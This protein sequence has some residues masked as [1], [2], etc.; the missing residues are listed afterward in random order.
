MI[1]QKPYQQEMV[2]RARW[3]VTIL[4][5]CFV[6]LI[7][8][9]L[10][11]Q[12]LQHPL[13][14]ERAFQ[15]HW[16]KQEL[17]ARRGEIRDRFGVLLSMSQEGYS[18]YTDPREVKNAA[19]TAQQL[20]PL[21]EMEE[22]KLCERLSHPSR[23]FV[24]LKRLLTPEK[25][26]QVQALKLPG[27]YARP[28]PRRVYPN[29]TLAAHVLGFTNVDHQGLEGVEASFD[30]ELT[31]TDG[32]TW[33]LR[34]GKLA[35]LGIYSPEAP[36]QPSCDGATVYLTIDTATQS[37]LEAELDRVV[38]EFHPT[39]IAGILI[40]AATGEIRAMAS[41]PTFDPNRF[42]DAPP[43]NWRNMVLA[44][45]YEVGSVMKPFVVAA[46]LAQNLVTADTVVFCHNGAYRIIPGRVIHDVHPYGNLTVGEIIVHSSNIGTA[47]IGQH[48]GA[49]Q[50]FSYLD[51]LGFGRRTGIT[52]PGEASGLLKPLAQWTSFTLTSVPMGY[53][54]C[55]T[56]LQMATAYTVLANDGV[57]I[58]PAIVRKLVYPDGTVQR[59][60]QP[61]QPQRIYPAQ[62][63][64]T[65]RTML[66][67]VVERGTARQANVIII[68]IAGKTG[69]AHKLDAN[70]QYSTSKYISVFA[71][72]APAENP[73]YCCVI[74]VDEPQ[75]SHY[76][77]TVAAPA[78]GRVL[79]EV[80]LQNYLSAQAPFDRMQAGEAK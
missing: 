74:L 22:A 57:Y 18:L 3:V 60:E 16:A 12:L 32:F 24:W 8:R 44:N 1:I 36:V 28:E 17:E 35:R 51:R 2:K 71:G 13:Y 77:G 33:V 66:R 67:D 20:A 76:G 46:A 4:T 79:Q 29:G 61:A 45:A 56:P 42:A 70:G 31:G 15:Q 37:I 41:R 54:V 19:A 14:R 47:I 58:P 68:Q 26:K 23:R 62:V 48:L 39:G 21:L 78:V 5:L 49:E 65:V 43:E 72:L 73:R 59:R 34:D 52:L 25:T 38:A 10:W 53:E 50:V 6:G 9:L 40:E 69:T 30:Q 55:V 7:V 75:G 63:A 11:V 27:I 80:C 64:T